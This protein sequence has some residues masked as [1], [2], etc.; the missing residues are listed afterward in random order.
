MAESSGSSKRVLT[1]R[2]DSEEDDDQRQ[3]CKYGEKCYRKNP[4]H[5]KEYRHP[6]MCWLVPYSILPLINPILFLTPE[7]CEILRLCLHGANIYSTGL[8]H[9]NTIFLPKN[10]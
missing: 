5:F 3:M 4:E 9:T 10:F 6:S 8:A 7:I 2:G 1:S